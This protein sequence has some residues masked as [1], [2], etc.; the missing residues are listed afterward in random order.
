MALTDESQ[1]RVPLHDAYTDIK[2]F[3][4]DDLQESIVLGIRFARKLVCPACEYRKASMQT[5][6]SKAP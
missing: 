4:S 2:R 6:T 1:R 3:V 5:P